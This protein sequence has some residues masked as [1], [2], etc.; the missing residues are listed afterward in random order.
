LRLARFRRLGTEAVDEGL[1]P[2]ALI[3]LACGE[4][5]LAREMFAPRADEILV[6][7]GV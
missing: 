1:K 6:A 2:L 7:A 3:F 5:L 4:R